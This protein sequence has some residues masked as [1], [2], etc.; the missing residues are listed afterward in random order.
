MSSCRLRHCVIWCVGTRFPVDCLQ[1]CLLLDMSCDHNGGSVCLIRYKIFFYLR[2]GKVT[3]RSVKSKTWDLREGQQLVLRIWCSS[4]GNVSTDL[5]STCTMDSSS[6]RGVL[7][8]GT[9]RVDVVVKICNYSWK[10]PDVLLWVND[11]SNWGLS[12]FYQ[13]LRVNVEIKSD[14]HFRISYPLSEPLHN[15]ERWHIFLLISREIYY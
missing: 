9:D 3:N 8:F 14:C 4:A 1:G 11:K 12:W 13:V 5:S 10:L 15:H 2:Q 6:R 7:L